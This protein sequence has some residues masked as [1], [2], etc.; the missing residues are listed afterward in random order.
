MNK[1]ATLDK[2]VSWAKRR[3]FTYQTSSIYGGLANNYDYGPY[4]VLLKNNIKDLWWKTFVQSRQDMV[5]LDGAILMQR[6]VW[7]A[8]GHE[9]GFNELVV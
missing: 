5:G 7:R 3:G 8:S 6:D 9:T 4:G 2:I 1:D